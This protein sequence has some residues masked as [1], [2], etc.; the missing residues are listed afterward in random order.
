MSDSPKL[1]LPP[2]DQWSSSPAR[3]GRGPALALGAGLLALF[4][5]QLYQTLKPAPA[6]PTAAPAPARRGTLSPPELKEVAIKLQRDNLHAAAAAVYEEYLS[7]TDLGKEEL[8]NHLF[9]V[10][11]LLVR[12]GNYEEALARYFKA[13]KLVSEANLGPLQ[14]RIQECLQ[15]LGKHAEQGYELA[16]GLAPRSALPGKTAGDQAAGAVVAWIGPEKITSSQLDDLV[17]K[18]IEE[19]VGSLYG[20]PPERLAELKAQAQKQYS[21]PQAKLGKLREILAREVLFREGIEREVEKGQSVQKRVEDFRREVVVQ[22]MVLSALRD[23]IKTTESDLRN[24]HRANP[25]RYQQPASARVRIAILADEAMARKLLEA[26]SEEEFAKLAGEH[27][28]EPATRERGGLLDEPVSEGRP[29]PVLGPA[30]ELQKAIL[31]TPA[32][33]TISAPVKLTAGYAAAYVRERSFE[34]TPPF[35]EVRERVAKDYLEEKE[36]EVQ[37]ALVK[38]LFDKHRVSIATD[39]FL[40]GAGEKAAEGTGAQGKNGSGETGEKAGGAKEERKDGP[41]KAQGAPS[42]S[43]PAGGASPAPEGAKE[44]P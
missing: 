32:Q 24:F 9:E 38:E 5:L 35:E 43:A 23:R 30:P 22:E 37:G 29:I 20:Y 25:A 33:K 41:A 44:R 26:K 1:T 39:Q 21:S 36:A 10:G 11:N 4:G 14:R 42:A 27:S 19:R 34:R 12:A 16:D 18:E 2:R 17:A 15:R 8:G 31:G 6:A 13:Q 7:S 28:L 40:H 3:S